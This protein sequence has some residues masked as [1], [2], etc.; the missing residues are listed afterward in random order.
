MDHPK[1]CVVVFRGWK[2]EEAWNYYD[3]A[4]KNHVEGWARAL[5]RKIV[6]GDGDKGFYTIKRGPDWGCI[7]AKLIRR[8]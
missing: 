1:G 6:D 3:Q 5:V 8:E 4:S 7:Y 2:I